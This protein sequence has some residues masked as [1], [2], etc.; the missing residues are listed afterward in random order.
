MK[1]PKTLS[2][3]SSKS[4]SLPRNSFAVGCARLEAS[5]WLLLL[6]ILVVL[7]TYGFLVFSY[8]LSIDEEWHGAADFTDLA[9]AWFSQGRWAMGLVSGILPN[10]VV[11]AVSTGL[12]VAL[13]AAS[14][15]MVS[16]KCFQLSQWKSL[17]I[18]SVTI[19]VP[20]TAFLL[21]FSTIALGIGVA[22][23]AS[24]LFLY[25]I[26]SEKN[27]HKILG[28]FAGAVAI[29]IY[30][31]FIAVLLVL[32]LFLV[33][34]TCRWKTLSR[35]LVSVTL[36]G[37]ISQIFAQLFKYL[38][39]ENSNYTDGFVDLQGLFTDPLL[40]ITEATKRVINV[41][42]LPESSFGLHSPWPVTLVI[43]LI[44]IA[45]AS[46]LFS[47]H[48]K[49]V[50]LLR[51]LVLI[52]VCL[53]PVGIEALSKDGLDFRAMVYIP[54]IIGG[55]VAISASA[56]SSIRSGPVRQALVTWLVVLCVLTVASSSAISNRLF[57]AS[58]TAYRRDMTLALDIDKDLAGLGLDT[59]QSQVPILTSG[60]HA[61]PETAMF[62]VKSTMGASFFAWDQG[63]TWRI[64]AFM[65]SVGV[66]V[67]ESKDPDQVTRLKT[68]LS[69]MPSYPQPGWIKVSEGVALIKLSN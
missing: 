48:P 12:G 45:L 24:F 55:L 44:V 27:T 5:P 28:I 51:F 32:S 23:V 53:V 2:I 67:V 18:S 7:L 13:T 30:F 37:I 57:A 69:E 50:K 22:S 46:I 17:A 58:D 63:Q 15:W 29:G 65:R 66:N 26:Q 64:A 21:S 56:L 8:S 33:Y 52:A 1:D 11:P 38:T 60:K 4:T 19:T 49:E 36:S 62:S 10:P 35:T 42:T 25:G 20:V 39:T 54:W 41:I 61:W 16:R 40:R 68:V 31:S 14:Y 34:K 43:F 3:D 59:N 9:H 6:Y 47:P